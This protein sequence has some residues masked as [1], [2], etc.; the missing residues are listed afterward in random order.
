MIDANAPRPSSS[1]GG[2]PR[3]KRLLFGDAVSDWTGVYEAWWTA[4][5]SSPTSR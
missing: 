2:V 5:L 3:F 4:N 1:R